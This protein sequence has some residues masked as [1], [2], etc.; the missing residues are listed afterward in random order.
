MEILGNT[1]TNQTEMEQK[2]E[3]Y[4]RWG[5]RENAEEEIITGRVKKCPL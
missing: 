4:A 2:R 1:Y 5:E 3:T